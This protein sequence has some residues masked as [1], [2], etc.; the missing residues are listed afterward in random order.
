MKKAKNAVKNII[1][2]YGHIIT[3]CA[4]AFIALTSNSSSVLVF[5]EPD[6]PAGLERFKKFNK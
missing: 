5:Y 1:C 4:F 3:C 2:K 6:E